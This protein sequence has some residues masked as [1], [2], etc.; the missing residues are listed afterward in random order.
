M[1]QEDDLVAAVGGSSASDQVIDCKRPHIWLEISPTSRKIVIVCVSTCL[2]E[3][4]GVNL[5]T[6][7]SFS[8]SKPVRAWRFPTFDA[9]IPASNSQ[10]HEQPT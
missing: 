6:N 1:L 9:T 2:G 10:F 3:R 5:E 4:E 7:S 8:A